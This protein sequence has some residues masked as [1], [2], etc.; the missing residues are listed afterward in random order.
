MIF[1]LSLNQRLSTTL[2]VSASERDL[3]NRCV[4]SYEQA[5]KSN[6]TPI[7][8]LGSNVDIEERTSYTALVGFLL[9][10]DRR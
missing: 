3:K 10:A 5:K 2:W 1:L 4:R 9:A 8:F 7:A 6:T